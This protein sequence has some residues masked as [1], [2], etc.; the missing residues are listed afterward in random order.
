[1]SEPII[2]IATLK[3]TTIPLFFLGVP[4]SRVSNH[5]NSARRIS[6]SRQPFVDAVVPVDQ[7]R[8]TFKLYNDH[9]LDH[10]A[11]CIALM[12]PLR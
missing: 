8:T 11:R 2:K 3:L 5:D 7:E 4:A 10:M 1:M 9:R 6:P 12:F